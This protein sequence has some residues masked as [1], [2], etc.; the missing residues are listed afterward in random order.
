MC[1]EATVHFSQLCVYMCMHV[2]M[3]MQLHGFIAKHHLMLCTFEQ[4]KL[5]LKYIQFSSVQSLSRV[6]LFATP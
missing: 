5:Y 3:D 6:R 4:L 1:Q 2:C